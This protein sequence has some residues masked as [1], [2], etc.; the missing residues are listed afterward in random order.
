MGVAILLVPELMAPS[1]FAL[2][3]ARRSSRNLLRSAA[4]PESVT[5]PDLAV[6]P[7][8][9]FL[10]SL[11]ASALTADRVVPDMLPC[12]AAEPMLG[13]ADSPVPSLRSAVPASDFTSARVAAGAVPAVLP[14]AAV[15][16]ADLAGSPVPSLRS[17]VVASV[18]TSARVAGAAGFCAAAKPDAAS[19]A[20]NKIDCVGFIIIFPLRE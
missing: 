6:S 9:S 12:V 10:G 7:V 3:A 8:P 11:P 2:A 18:F 17:P 15:P 5:P 13:L 16:V 20:A 19:S 14:G 4:D 1:R